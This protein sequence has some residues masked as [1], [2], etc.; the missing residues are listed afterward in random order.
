MTAPIRSLEPRDEPRWRALFRAYIAFYKADVADSVL[1]RT[2]SRL[3]VCIRKRRYP[4]EQDALA[5][6]N[7]THL[8]LRPYRCERCRQFHLTSRTKGKRMP[9]PAE[10]T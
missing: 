9:R 5:M 7:R 1:D 6:V 8:P 2:W 4:S 10:I 3:S